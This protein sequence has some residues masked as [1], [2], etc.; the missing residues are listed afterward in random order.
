MEQ[1]SELCR[2]S[3]DLQIPLLIINPHKSIYQVSNTST[4]GSAEQMSKLRHREE[5][6]QP[7][8]QACS[9]CSSDHLVKAR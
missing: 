8:Q 4:M 6:V 5:Q 3:P 7:H 9:P 2:V 1:L